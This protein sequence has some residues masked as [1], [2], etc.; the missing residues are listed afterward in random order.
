MLGHRCGIGGAA[1]RQAA[2]CDLAIRAEALH[3]LHV[4]CVAAEELRLGEVIEVDDL[5]AV[6]DVLVSPG[7]DLALAQAL[8]SPLFGASDAGLAR[9]MAQVCDGDMSL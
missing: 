7:N 6:L 5:V 4:P 1:H 2:G 3:A 8:K 9:I